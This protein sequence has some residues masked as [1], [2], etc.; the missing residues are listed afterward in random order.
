MEGQGTKPQL[1][2]INW[3][4][5]AVAGFL[6]LIVI[7][8]V[9]KFAMAPV[10]KLAE[11]EKEQTETPQV[12]GEPILDSLQRLMAYKSALLSLSKKD[13][14]HL[15]VNV[16]DSTLGLFIN[17]VVI[18]SAKLTKMKIDPLLSKLPQGMYIQF[19]S[20]PLNVTSSEATIVKEPIIE[21]IAP[22]SPEELMASVTTPDTLVHQ[23]VFVKMITENGIH[24]FIS[25]NENLTAADKSAYRSF[26]MNRRME[27]SE[28]FL[29]ALTRFKPYDYQP[30]IDLELSDKA[31]TAIYRALPEKPKVVVWYE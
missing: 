16:P 10:Q 25:Q 23:P 6:L 28:C 5:Y 18:Y 14:I 30:L 12:Y 13:S 7:L 22:K 1:I 17:G 4:V 26:W 8:A 19:F 15:L 29:S 21:K 27:R 31:L 11:W 9:V 3:T 24:L 2:K 20:Q